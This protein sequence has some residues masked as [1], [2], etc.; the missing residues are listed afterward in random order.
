[1]RDSPGQVDSLKMDHRSHDSVGPV[2]HGIMTETIRLQ[3]DTAQDQQERRL[4]A[5]KRLVT[6]ADTDAAVIEYCRAV[7]DPPSYERS[8]TQAK[9]DACA[10]RLALAQTEHTARRTREAR[11]LLTAVSG[12]PP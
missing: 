4:Q 1:M 2:A 3:N 7:L 6:N 12:S 10:A 5:A 8:H 9:L 11:Q